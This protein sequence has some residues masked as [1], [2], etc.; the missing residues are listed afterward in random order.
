VL[1]ARDFLH[2]RGNTAENVVADIIDMR[3]R[4]RPPDNS[5][6]MEP[7]EFRRGDWQLGSAMMCTRRESARYEAHRLE[8]F[9]KQGH[10]HVAHVPIHFALDNG[11]HYTLLGLFRYRNDEALM[12][13]VYRLAGWMECV[14][15]AP[16]PIL[17]TDLLRRFYKSILDEREALRLVWRGNVRYFLFPIHVDFYN[18]NLLVHRVSQTESLKELYTAIE[19][20]TGK[21]FD[22]LAEHYVFYLPETLAV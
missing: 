9:S 14:T 18:P 11:C 17:R 5:I 12:R 7:L 3:D 1:H 4:N 13:R 22:I 20:E 16:S 2:L 19:E 8:A 21:Q 6:T 15:N 10:T